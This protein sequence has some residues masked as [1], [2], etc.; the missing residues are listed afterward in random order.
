MAV[1]LVE[2]DLATE[3]SGPIRRLVRTYPLATFIVLAYLVN[4]N[5]GFRAL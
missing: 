5:M 2:H 3:T 4:M 1:G